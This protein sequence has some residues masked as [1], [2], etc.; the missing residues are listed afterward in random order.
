[1]YV[2]VTRDQYSPIPAG[3]SV[4]YS[5]ANRCVGVYACLLHQ[6]QKPLTGVTNDMGNQILVSVYVC[7]LMCV[8]TVYDQ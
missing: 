8:N 1:M 5:T 4:H 7:G 2:C 3:V 6:G